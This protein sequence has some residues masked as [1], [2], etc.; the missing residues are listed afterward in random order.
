ML[1]HVMVYLNGN[2]MMGKL[3]KV[4]ATSNDEAQRLALEEARK[5]FGEIPEEE[6]EKF[7]KM[8]STRSAEVDIPHLYDLPVGNFSTSDNL[9]TSTRGEK[10]RKAVALMQQ[11]RVSDGLIM[12]GNIEGIIAALT[13]A[14]Q[15]A[16]LS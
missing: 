10:L 4:K 7:N 13:K 9:V 8:M 2:P 3:F 5:L 12:D 16:A 11:N 14:D 15:E 6:M 1:C